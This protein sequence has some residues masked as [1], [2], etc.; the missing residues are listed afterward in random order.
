[1]SFDT[2][3]LAGRQNLKGK[4][5]RVMKENGKKYL[6]AGSIFIAGFIT[7]TILVQKVDVQP[8]GIYGTNIGFA[9]INCLFHELTGVHMLIYFITDWLG[10]IPMILSKI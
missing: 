9:T 3:K 5:Q 4:G 7:W 2:F 10:L 6:F 1:M 8:L